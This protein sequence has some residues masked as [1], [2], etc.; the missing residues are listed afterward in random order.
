MPF[1]DDRADGHQLSRPMSGGGP[2][3][4]DGA[5]PPDALM[6]DA[7][8]HNAQLVA[9]ADAGEE[10]LERLRRDLAAATE[11]VT[12]AYRD[13]T[14]LIRLFQVF[15]HR[16]TPD[17][18]VEET[19][20]VLSEVFFADVTCVAGVFGRR[21]V[22]TGACGLAEDDPAYTDG[23]ALT[24]GAERALATGRPVART[25]DFEVGDLPGP[26]AGL[27]ISS[28]AWLPL[29][30]DGT[31]SELLMLFRRR[32]EPFGQS[33]LEVLSSVAYRLWLAV[34]ERER[35][36]VMERLAVSGHRLARH[37]DLEPL[38]DEAVDLLRQLASA[39]RAWIVTLES[40]QA[41]LRAHRG[42]PPV[43]WP[44]P[45]DTLDRWA[46]PYDTIARPATP[47]LRV[48]VFHEGVP[49]AVLFAARERPRP[50]TRDVRD[51]M[52]IFA[53]QLGV[54]IANADL[55]RALRSAA[56]HDSLTGL[57]NR[58]LVRQRL[59]DALGRDAPGHVGLLFCDLDGFKAVN[60]RLGHETGDDLLQQVAERL[61]HS[62][63]PRDLLARFGGDEFVIVIDGVDDLAEVTKMGWRVARALE[64]PFPLSG[65]RVRVS[66]SV[67]GVLGVRGRTTASAM[68]RDADA[69][70]YAAKEQ[71]P[72]LIEVFDDDASHRSRDRL[73]L[74]SELSQAL[75]RNELRVRYQPI[76]DLG[77][78]R[79]L[80]F[81]ALLCWTHPYRGQ[82]TAEEF[83]PHAEETGAIVRIGQWVLE[84]ACRQL[85][86]WRRLPRCG[87]LGVSVNVSAAQLGHPRLVAQTLKV[88]RDAGVQPADVWL[89]I[90]EHSN[91]R[92]EVSESAAAL[93][94]AGV[95]FAL[96][97]FGTAYSN[98]GHLRRFPFETVKIDRSFVEGVA[99][100]EGD[101]S[102]VRAILAFA[103][104]LGLDA[105]AEGV[106]TPEQ[107]AA[108]LSL[109][110]RIGQGD[111][112][113]PPMS[114]DQAAALLTG[115]PF[116]DP[117]FP[118]LPQAGRSAPV[119]RRV[120][121][122]RR[123][124]AELAGHRPS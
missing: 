120:T 39:D 18:L 110:C 118:R 87:A 122:R 33:D 123:N 9:P 102:I 45:G 68:L 82:V 66:A 108:L 12:A 24:G 81:E 53:N 62:V 59:D 49:T 29:S 48:P 22:V 103:D 79:I 98:L 21:L 32:G 83:L 80:A 77:S 41:R 63:R 88:I 67:G 36:A 56:T 104:S 119:P 6:R 26:V 95:H 93:R 11:A 10:E 114:A 38:L 72:G 71:G 31:A 35:T 42:L 47:T 13:T 69:A 43:G 5:A 20:A 124:R 101:R 86:A 107:R 89:E 50:F 84:Q 15:G 74:R 27:E 85:A 99:G 1:S 60:D 65:E 90:T 7:A 109:G 76:V 58:V 116:T 91:V 117:A 75:D 25:G 57:A 8:P 46:A 111:L 23:W 28:A 14:R 94:E 51:A 17:E 2:D 100:R 19:L 113:A 16:L 121:G 96:D 64:D 112:V 115:P 61:R 73:H 92:E 34:Q 78:G 37:L 70:M 55:C 30:T 105:V 3:A 40:G 106:E 54:A 4:E 44:R 52:N 97:D